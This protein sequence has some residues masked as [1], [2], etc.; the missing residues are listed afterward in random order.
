MSEEQNNNYR[1]RADQH[2]VIRE[3]QLD[4]LY[5]LYSKGVAIGNDNI[6]LLR[7]NG[8]LK[9]EIPTPP[10]KEKIV[11]DHINEHLLNQ[12]TDRQREIER[13]IDII[14]SDGP[15]EKIEILTSEEFEN[16]RKLYGHIFE[17]RKTPITKEDWIP[18]SR[19]EHTKEF[20]EFI[21]SINTLG[22]KHKTNY[23]KFQL[24]VQQAYQW[25]QEN[26]SYTDFYDDEEQYEYTMNEL[27]RCDENSLYFLNK[28]VYY[29]EGDE[30][31][32]R[33][34]Y[35]A[36]PV[37]ELMAYLDDC[38]Y[39]VA[40]AKGRQ[41]AATTTLMALD[42]KDSIFKPNHFMKFITEDDKKAQEIFEDKLKYPFSQLPVW[43]TPN[44]L[45]ERDNLF[46][47]GHKPEKGKKEG[48]G[49]KILVE[50]PK[51]TAIAGG[52]PQKVK[53]DEAGNIGI[54]GM[55]LNNARPTRFFANPSTK[56]LELKRQVWFWGT[57]GEMDKGGKSFETEFMAIYN[58]FMEGNFTDGV[59]PLF[60]DW[61][62][63][64]F[65]TQEEYDNE[66]RVAYSKQGPDR[67][68]SI[69]EFHQSYPSSLSDVFRTSAKTLADDS[70]ITEAERRI[71]DANASSNVRLTKKGYFEPIYDFSQPF[72]EGMDAPF[73]IIGANF[74]PTEDF[75][76]MASV[77]IFFDPQ[78]GWENRYFKGTDP[79]DTD[80]GLSMFSSTVWDKYLKCPV[81]VLNWRVNDYKQVFMQSMLMNLYY[82]T[83]DVK[84]GIK[85][86][87][88]SNRGTS[89]TQYLTSHGYDSEL[90]LNYQLPPAFQN[91]TTIN[92]GVGI[93]NK[94]AR[95]TMIINRMHEMITAYGDKN[96]FKIFFEQLKTF[97]CNISENGKEIW[98][99]MNKKY[100][101]DDVL[102]SHVFS[103][104]CGELCFP[105]LEPDNL[106]KEKPRTKIVFETRYDKDYNLIR[107]PVKVRA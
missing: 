105:E 56:K 76:P 16:R 91:K 93:D 68:K 100:F 52:A 37:H 89:Y 34:K 48:V 38:G 53:I 104:I 58:S 39:S 19:V 43:M 67:E 71:Q 12:T 81:A 102:Y 64:P 31:S 27:A 49:S 107:V 73:K 83:K 87:V 80:T 50:P 98:G 35:T 6:V 88:E 84:T 46:K 4:L 11:R 65:I 10:E 62:N 42:V 28:Y 3:N 54:L 60:F 33:V 17:G 77:E 29:K 24:Y 78:P 1:G 47:L 2:R 82:D 5:Q 13:N 51:R 57:G 59:V 26:R 74:I 79:I 41:I 32:G 101:R 85:E 61:T 30:T 44:V 45:N 86:L 55:M 25:L 103:Y 23:R 94:G 106:F 95:S 66:K 96:Y 40:I 8:F 90:V 15:V 97:V 70:Y 14:E 20:I 69:T 36:R 21:I 99:P 22:F 75:D 63:R 7:E 72:Q 18:E 9:N 92:E